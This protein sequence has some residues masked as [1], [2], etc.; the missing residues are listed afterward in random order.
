MD[1]SVKSSSEPAFSEPVDDEEDLLAN[2]PDVARLLAEVQESCEGECSRGPESETGEEGG[3]GGK[4]VSG[5][6][7]EDKVDAVGQENSPR[8]YGATSATTR[9]RH[10]DENG[11]Q[12][13]QQQAGSSCGTDGIETGNCRE[14][15]GQN[16]GG[17]VLLEHSEISTATEAASTTQSQQGS[18]DISRI[19]IDGLGSA[20]RSEHRSCSVPSICLS[21]GGCSRLSRTSTMSS[22]TLARAASQKLLEATKEAAEQASTDQKNEAVETPHRAAGSAIAKADERINVVRQNAEALQVFSPKRVRRLY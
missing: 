1:S 11:L 15:G 17:T 19:K 6:R 22:Y 13:Q 16:N 7:Q 10:H 21:A 8:E 2:D 9:R 18:I 20:G 5:V 3:T 14:R 12:Q 4:D